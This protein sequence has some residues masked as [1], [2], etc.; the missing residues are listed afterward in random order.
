MHELKTELYTDK[1][2]TFWMFTERFYRL[3]ILHDPYTPYNNWINAS[4]LARF[5]KHEN[6]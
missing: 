2:A 4:R 1:G 5:R 3:F 6:M